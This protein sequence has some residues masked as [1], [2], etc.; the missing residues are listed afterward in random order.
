MVWNAPID[1]P[2]KHIHI[3]FREAYLG[4]KDSE[5]SASEALPWVRRYGFPERIQ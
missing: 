2:P 3:D 4:C 1:P 5:R